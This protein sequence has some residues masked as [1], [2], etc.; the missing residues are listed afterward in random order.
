MKVGIIRCEKNID[1]CAMRSCFKSIQNKDNAFTGYDNIELVGIL[2]CRCPGDVAVARAKVLTERKEA[3]V[4]FF[5]TCAFASK[6]GHGVYE[7]KKGSGYCD[8]LDEILKKISE[9]AKVRVV[10][11]TA[12]F[13]A[14]YKA[15]SYG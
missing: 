11:G 6:I 13:P 4:I 15:E 5:V 12:H 2:P 9:E 14:G 7:F 8:N 1:S 3:E 10:K